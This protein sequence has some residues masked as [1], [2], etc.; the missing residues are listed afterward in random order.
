MHLSTSSKPP[1]G[2]YLTLFKLL[3]ASLLR[4]VRAAPA[5]ASRSGGWT[6]G[7]GVGAAG[8]GAVLWKRADEE[9][10]NQELWI[11][12]V[13]SIAFVL[14]GGIFSGLT[15][16]LMGLDSTNLKV[17]ASSGTPQ[18]QHDARAVLSLL[19]RGRHW[20]LV[21][22]L[23]GNVLVNETLPVFLDAITGG[24]GLWAV[25]ISA[26]A[27][28]VF[29]E[30]LP[31]ALCARHGLRIGAK[32]VGFVTALMYIEGAV[33]YPIAKLLDYLL[34][35]SHGTLYRKIELK[36]LV[37]LHGQ[38]GGDSLSE[39]EV[40][41]ISAVLDL[42]EKPVSFIMTPIAD[43]YT[44]S[45]D[46]KLDRAKVDEILALGHSR[47]PVHSAHRST[48]FLG[49]LIVKKLI[50]YDPHECKTVG[51]F[52]LTALPETLPGSTCL[53]ALNYFQGGSSHMLLVSDTPGLEGGALGVVSLEDVVE[54][55]LG[56]EIIDETDLFVDNHSRI[57]VVRKDVTSRF[58]ESQSPRRTSLGAMGLA[59]LVKGIID[60]R[61]AL[62]RD[63]AST[64]AGSI[65][66][67]PPFSP[68]SPA[69][70]LTPTPSHP[71]AQQP[72]ISRAASPSYSQPPTTTSPHRT[73]SSLSNSFTSASAA[74]SAFIK[75]FRIPS[76]LNQQQ[77]GYRQLASFSSAGED[78]EVD[79]D[80]EGSPVPHASPVV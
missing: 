2:G 27:I 28:V 69:F 65:S 22:L 37:G 23:L 41:I 54:E 44:L 45:S 60:R 71:L 7:A 56:K 13:C 15:L 51:S 46:V 52:P 34:G 24:G 8:A 3:V 57:P 12:L 19:S 21:S 78:N 40:T 66:S 9:L 39:D 33:A 50:T 53:D 29:G 55:L 47:V 43:V 73:T 10:S 80:V 38:I 16:G 64:T 72:T 77:Q 35:E 68:S 31:Q 11:K 17:L 58:S 76:G 20:V 48:D 79:S 62:R 36:T 4:E 1:I 59:P 75:P 18:Q 67:V 6:S 61:V 49:M 30:V 74:A 26:A 63:S 70:A 42:S 25:L 14:I 32:C 5:L